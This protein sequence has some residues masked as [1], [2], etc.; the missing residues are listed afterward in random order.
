MCVC[1]C[2]CVCVCAL[3]QIFKFYFILSE[4]DHG[5][6][7]HI[8]TSTPASQYAILEK[9]DQINCLL[10]PRKRG[11]RKSTSILAYKIFKK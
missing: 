11:G 2:V 4:I 5:L 1:V 9:A 6:P 7:H 8:I 10:G 3:I